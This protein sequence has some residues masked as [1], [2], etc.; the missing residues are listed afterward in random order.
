MDTHSFLWFIMG[1]PQLSAK[2]RTLIEEERNEKLFSI[3]SLWEMAIK[4]SLGKLH[5]A[6]PFE[7]LIPHQLRFNGIE[8]LNIKMEHIISDWHLQKRLDLGQKCQYS[9]STES[10]PRLHDG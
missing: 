1:S 4:V 3:A 8:L 10:N 2:A 5:V 7:M 6:E 9:S